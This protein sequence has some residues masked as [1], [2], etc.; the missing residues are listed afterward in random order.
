MRVRGK[1]KKQ[2][3]WQDIVPASVL[4]RSVQPTKKTAKRRHEIV[5]VFPTLPK[6]HI[7]KKI[8]HLLFSTRR[9]KI[10]A[11]VILL[12]LLVAG[13]IFLIIST[14]N[15]SDSNADGSATDGQSRPKLVSGTPDYSTLLPSGKTIDQLGG[16]TRVS[17]PNSSAV[18]TYVDKVGTTQLNVSEQPLPDAFKDAP[19]KQVE[20]LA[21]SFSA[22]EKI[23]VGSTIVHIGTYGKDAQRIIFTKKNLLILITASSVMTTNQWATYINSLN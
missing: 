22:N 5:I 16:W 9:R 17:P 18:F 19:S 15:P 14:H 13:F 11:G 4:P 1:Q 12:L 10:I 6:L 20:A 8:H 3:I 7:P 21:T 2:N 23:T